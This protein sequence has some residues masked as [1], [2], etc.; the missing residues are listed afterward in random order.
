M[1]LVTM[2]RYLKCALAI[3]RELLRRGTAIGSLASYGVDANAKE[4]MPLRRACQR[5]QTDFDGNRLC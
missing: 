1:I 2:S 4:M 5:R 3:V